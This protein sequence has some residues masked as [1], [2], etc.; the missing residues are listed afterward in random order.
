MEMT[1]FFQFA[2]SGFWTFVGTVFLLALI[3]I[4]AAN[5]LSAIFHGQMGNDDD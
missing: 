5:C 3:G 1:E 4:V 2:L